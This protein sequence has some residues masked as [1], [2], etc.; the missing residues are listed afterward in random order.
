MEQHLD[1]EQRNHHDTMK[2]V[3]KTDRRLKE[4]AFQTE[5]DRKNQLR[6]QDLVDKLQNKLKIYKRQIEETE[7]IANGNLPKIRKLQLDLEAAEGRA[8]QAE[9][10]INR[11][12]QSKQF[13]NTPEVIINLY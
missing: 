4:L 6:L 5:E 13:K 9:S 1:I 12:R 7:E 2:E 11:C 8:I 10:Q 3:R